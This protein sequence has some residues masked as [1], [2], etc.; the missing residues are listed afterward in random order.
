MGRGGEGVAADLNRVVGSW[1]GV[2]ITPMFGRFGYFVGEQ[3]FGCYPIRPRAH[4]L[5]VRLSRSD[6]A[7]ALAMPG[8]RPHR[9]F[10]NR[11]WIECDLVEPESVPWALRWLRRAYE[12]AR[13]APD[14]APP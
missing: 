1:L 5:W 10:A 3:M 12:Q 2:R 8:A 4:D 11:G 14:D 6:Q 7:R 9:R 13:R